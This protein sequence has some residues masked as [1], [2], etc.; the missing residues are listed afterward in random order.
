LNLADQWHVPRLRF[1][2]ACAPCE[3]TLRQKTQTTKP[4]RRDGNEPASCIARPGAN[5]SIEPAKRKDGK[6]RADGLVKKAAGER[7]RGAG[8]G[9]VFLAQPSALAAVDI[10]AS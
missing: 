3:T 4:P 9:L 1:P 8:N 5:R 10:K 7:A 6:N 2:T